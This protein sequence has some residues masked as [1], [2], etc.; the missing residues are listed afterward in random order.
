MATSFENAWNSENVIGLEPMGGLHVR[1]YNEGV[2]I[3]AATSACADEGDPM[4]YI[5][6]GN[7]VE[8]FSRNG[9]LTTASVEDYEV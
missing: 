6:W 1:E 2:I 5:C 7:F 9:E 4:T 3:E 8:Q